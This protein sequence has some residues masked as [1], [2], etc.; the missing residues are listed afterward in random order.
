LECF[1]VTELGETCSLSQDSASLI[2]WSTQRIEVLRGNK[3]SF[4]GQSFDQ[5]WGWG[6]GQRISCTVAQVIMYTTRPKLL[7]SLMFFGSVLN[8]LCVGQGNG[9]LDTGEDEY[10]RHGAASRGAL[11]HLM[12]RPIHAQLVIISCLAWSERD[13]TRESFFRELIPSFLPPKPLVF[14]L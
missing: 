10:R 14:L 4:L 1:W 5:G 7:S 8:V 9:H 2:L 13:T 3:Q 12:V 6:I 11:R